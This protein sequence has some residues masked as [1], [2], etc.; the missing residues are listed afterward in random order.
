MVDDV[1]NQNNASGEMLSKELNLLGSPENKTSYTSSDLDI[2]I[3]SM[4]SNIDSRIIG[5]NHLQRLIQL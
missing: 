2:V 5:L 1:Q 3:E 4:R